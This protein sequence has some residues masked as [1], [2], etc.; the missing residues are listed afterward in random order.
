MED[1]SWQVGFC[2]SLTSEDAGLEYCTGSRSLPVGK[3]A[4]QVLKDGCKGG[5]RS[6]RLFLSWL[7]CLCL[8]EPESY[9]EI[10]SLA[11]CSQTLPSVQMTHCTLVFKFSM[12]PV[13]PKFNPLGLC[14][15]HIHCTSRG[16]NLYPLK[17]D[18]ELDAPCFCPVLP[19]L[20]ASLSAPRSAKADFQRHSVLLLVLP[21]QQTRGMALCTS[22][23]QGRLSCSAWHAG[24]FNTSVPHHIKTREIFSKKETLS[25]LLLVFPSVPQPQDGRRG[26]GRISHMRPVNHLL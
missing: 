21:W 23:A 25:Q 19:W 22:L 5:G 6:C 26:G 18:A 11:N 8:W 10:K 1:C 4:L 3:S 24:F 16:T 9:I 2:Q 13:S 14:V 20:L 15:P 7:L 17:R 12:I